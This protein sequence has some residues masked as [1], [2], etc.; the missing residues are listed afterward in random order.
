MHS[1]T[2]ILPEM[3]HGVDPFVQ[4]SRAVLTYYCAKSCFRSA[5]TASSSP[6]SGKVFYIVILLRQ[7]VAT[8]TKCTQQFLCCNVEAHTL[9]AASTTWKHYCLALP[10][11]AA[12]HTNMHA[13][14]RRYGNQGSWVRHVV[15]PCGRCR[16][17]LLFV[18]FLQS[19]WFKP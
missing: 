19:L 8:H 16:C 1:S 3:L 2:A 7:R 11:L 18:S 6:C 10:C 13:C 15:E 17:E 4:D 5:V 9:K 14:C 12:T